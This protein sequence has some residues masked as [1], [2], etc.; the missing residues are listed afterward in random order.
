ME[1]NAE[2]IFDFVVAYFVA[3][4]QRWPT[5]IPAFLYYAKLHNTHDYIP[6]PCCPPVLVLVHAQPFQGQESG[7]QTS[8]TNWTLGVKRALARY[9]FPDACVPLHTAPLTDHK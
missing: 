7:S 6:F 5:R 4:G 9:E 3:F 2:N 8:Q 1:N